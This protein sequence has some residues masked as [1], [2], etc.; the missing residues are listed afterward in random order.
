MLRRVA[1][2]FECA[3]LSLVLV[4][5]VV[6]GCLG[7]QVRADEQGERERRAKVAL[8]LAAK[9]SAV[10]VAP[11]PR[12]A[13]K[14]YPQGYSAAT[15]QQ[16]PLVVYVGCEA[17]PVPGAVVA[18]ADAPFAGVHGPAVVVAFPVGDKLLIDATVPPDAAKVE[19]AVKA[20]QRK[21][22]VPVLPQRMPAAPKPL[23]W[24]L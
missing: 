1:A 23:S 24:N 16:Q 13:A 10:A 7:S 15:K 19:M 2:I 6:A 3:A 8:A 11:P 20:A 21:I 14:T 18:K 5:F 17:Q 9:P 4:A 12:P 22:D